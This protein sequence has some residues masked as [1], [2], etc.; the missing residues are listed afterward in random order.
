VTLTTCERG[1]AMEWF[2]VLMYGGLI[3]L[4]WWIRR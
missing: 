1:G 3:D 4:L 2:A